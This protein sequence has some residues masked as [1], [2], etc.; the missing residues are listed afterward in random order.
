M[1]DEKLTVNKELMAR[2]IDGKA[3]RDEIRR[4][5]KLDPK[6]EERFWTYLEVLQEKTGFKEKIL[7]RI[8][9]H[10]YIVAADGRRVVKC[11]CGHEFGDYRVNWKLN[12]LIRV[13]KTA[14]QMTELYADEIYAPE[15]GWVEIREFYCPG[16]QALLSVEIAPPGYPS[17]FEFLPDLGGLYREWLGKSLPDESPDWFQDKTSAELSR[18]RAEV[19]Q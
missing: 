8:S 14:S 3:N 19:G 7:L 1:A 10:L 5:Q 11:D 4:L 9:D 12:A 13:R 2:L 6:D 18:W 15:E 16:C 17:W